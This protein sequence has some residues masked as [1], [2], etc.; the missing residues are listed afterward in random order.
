[1]TIYRWPTNETRRCKIYDAHGNR[2]RHVVML[3]TDTGELERYGLSVD[4][5]ASLDILVKETIA[6]PILIKW[7]S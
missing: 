3:N 4:G 7:I 6:I 5:K 2:I 1:M